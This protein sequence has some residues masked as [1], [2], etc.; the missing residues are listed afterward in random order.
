[1]SEPVPPQRP[2]LALLIPLGAL[3][4]IAAL[5]FGF[6]RILLGIPHTVA[7]AVA[8]MTAINV[9]LLCAVLSSRPRLGGFGMLLL[10]AVAL[11]PTA[12]GGGVAAGIIPTAEE[13]GHGDEAKPAV[14][15][16]VAAQLAFG[17]KELKLPAPEATIRLRNEDTVPHNVSIYSGENVSNA[18]TLLQGRIIN[19]GENIDYKV[20]LPG[21]GSYFFRCDVHPTTMTGQVVVEEKG[22]G[23]AAAGGAKDLALTAKDLTFDLKELELVAGT[24]VVLRLRNDDTVPHNVAIFEG[25]NA[26]GKKLFAGELFTGPATKQYRFKAPPAGTYHFHCDVHPNMQGKVVVH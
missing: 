4:V 12:I 11:V 24:D 15:E 8:L 5:V 23:G 20:D 19:G 9:L 26:S 3:A 2:A 18:K 16:I 10:L 21:P 7:V 14:V 17:K 6:S 1:M 25:M 13:E 22:A